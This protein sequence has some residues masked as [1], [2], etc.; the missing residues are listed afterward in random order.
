VGDCASRGERE[1][2]KERD[3]SALFL[4]YQS[5]FGSWAPSTTRFPIPTVAEINISTRDKKYLIKVSLK[6]T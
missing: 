1:K 2:E 3:F 6:I 4:A 5:L